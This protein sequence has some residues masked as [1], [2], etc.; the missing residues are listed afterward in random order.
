MADEIRETFALTVAN[1]DFSYTFNA[2]VTQDQTGLGADSGIIQVG[3]TPE[4]LA[5]TDITTEGVLLLR[6]LDSSN[7]V[8]YGSDDYVGGPNWFGRIKAGEV[9]LLRL[10]PGITLTWQADTAEVKV[11][12]LLLED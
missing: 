5:F 11:F 1:G 2:Q 6:N 7:F 9:H 8:T 4:I 10:E 3:T 12:Y